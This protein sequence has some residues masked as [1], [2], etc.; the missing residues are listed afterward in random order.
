MT[1]FDFEPEDAWDAADPPLEQARNLA[2]RIHALDGRGVPRDSNVRVL[3]AVI[4]HRAH[5]AS[6]RDNLTDRQLL[7]LE[8]IAGDLEYVRGRL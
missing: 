5:R 2:R 3:L 6:M 7:R 8:Q 4:Q 1:V